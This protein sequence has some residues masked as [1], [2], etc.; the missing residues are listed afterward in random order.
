MDSRG[1]RGAMSLIEV[2]VAMTVI[3]IGLMAVFGAV[4]NSQHA[5]EFSRT[6]NR[7]MGEIEKA[8]ERIQ[9]A[10]AIYGTSTQIPFVA[11]ESSSFDVA[12]NPTNA[13]ASWPGAAQ[14]LTVRRKATVTGAP[15]QVIPLVITVRWRQDNINLSTSCDYFYAPRP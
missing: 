5:N 14:L 10:A 13:L 11:P 7:V 2:M 8:A 3:T 6:R 15:V 4:G 12:S 9:A 1:T